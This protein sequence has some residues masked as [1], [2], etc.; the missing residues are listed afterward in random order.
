MKSRAGF[1]LIELLVGLVILAIVGLLAWRGLDSILR[2]K[3]VIENRMRSSAQI[4]QVVSQW[5]TDCEMLVRLENSAVSPALVHQN[6]LWLLRR[7]VKNRDV[8][9]QI[10]R[11]QLINQQLERSV[12]RLFPI[13]TTSL[14]LWV[15]FSREMD[16]RIGS[17]QK[18]FQVDFVERQEFRL[19]FNSESTKKQLQGMQVEW[20]FK[21]TLLPLSKS[22]LSGIRI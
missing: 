15:G 2:A 13:D 19:F 11:Y 4:D 18:T 5:V 7:T 3:D 9:W 21:D 10:V 1:A 17:F 6:S 8:H 16:S 20:W 22:C 14:E 12:S